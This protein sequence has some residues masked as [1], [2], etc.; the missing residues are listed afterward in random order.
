V[1][2]VAFTTLGCK[3]NFSETSS[4]SAQFEQA[5]YERIESDEQADI[6]VINTCTVTELANKK[7]KQAIKKIISRNPDAKIIAVGCY[8]QLKPDEVANIEGVDLILGSDNKFD[9]IKELM[10][11]NPD[12]NV[13]IIVND[14]RI[15]QKFTPSYSYG[16]RTRSFLKVQ[17][18]CDYFC[19]YCAIP[20]ARGRSRNNSIAETVLKAK[21]IVAKGIKEII[22]TGVNIGDFG[23]ASNEDFFGLVNALD[24]VEGLQRLR[25]SSIEPNLL[26]DAMLEF[27]ASSRVVV[28]HFHLPLQCGTDNLLRSMRRRYTTSFYKKRVQK[29]K[30]IMPQ[31]CIAADIIVGVPGETD[32]EFEKSCEFVRSV[33][34]S[35]L[36]VFTYSERENTM[37]VKMPN[38]VPL[39]VRKERSKI[40]H[41]LAEEKQLIFQLQHLNTVRKVLFEAQQNGNVMYGF[42]DNYIKVEVPFNPELINDTKNVLLVSLTDDGNVLG[43][44]IN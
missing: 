30:S 33:D 32:E 16:D 37:A 3:L 19:S 23:K 34:V 2:K 38:Q 11:L 18:G 17:D 42:T 40:M 27:A 39:G 21:E 8:A 44:V 22:L 29:I 7:S 6:F 14:S 9:I 12:G 25:I 26:T 4:I 15:E 24:S 20:H 35:Y 28:P 10:Q 41:Q 1:Q 13:K 36:H 31:A 43:K 5:G